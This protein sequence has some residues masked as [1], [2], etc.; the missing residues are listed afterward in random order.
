MKEIL[1]TKRLDKSNKQSL[2]AMGWD[3]LKGGCEADENVTGTNDRVIVSLAHRPNQRRNNLLD[4]LGHNMGRVIIALTKYRNTHEREDGHNTMKNQVRRSGGQT[5]NQEEG[6]ILNDRA[7]RLL[8]AVNKQVP[9]ANRTV[10]L[11]LLVI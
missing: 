9:V 5:S 8:N 3:M 1:R 10:N 7:R 6:S 2:S 4:S 11:E